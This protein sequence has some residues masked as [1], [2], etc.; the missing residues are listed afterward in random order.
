MNHFKRSLLTL[1]VLGFAA[2]LSMSA[3]AY[4]QAT[5][6]T[7][8][9]TV[10]DASGGVIVG[11]TVTAKNQST[12]VETQTR[13]TGDGIYSIPNLPPGRYSITVESAGFR[14]AVITDVLVRLGQD[15][16]VDVV[17][18][19]GGLEET[20]T[21]VAGNEVLLQR[22]QSQVSTTFEARKIQELPLN[23]AGAAWTSSL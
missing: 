14:R 6:G 2:L 7:I 5:T 1:F 21:V 19:P 11:A 20:V 13:T 22:D 3:S 15:S 9:G 23:V 8:R 10:T 17:L 12:N 16:T 4:A 18:Q